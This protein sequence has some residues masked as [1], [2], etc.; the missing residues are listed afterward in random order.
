[1]P[2]MHRWNLKY[3][4]AFPFFYLCIRGFKLLLWQTKFVVSYNTL[5][6]KG[7]IDVQSGEG[8]GTSVLI[9]INV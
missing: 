4:W 8:K 6:L 9:E 1:M 2:Q 7:K 3:M 5:F